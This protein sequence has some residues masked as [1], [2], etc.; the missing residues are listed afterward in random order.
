MRGSIESSPATGDPTYL[1]SIAVPADL[2][3]RRPAQPRQRS[4]M[5]LVVYGFST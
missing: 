2:S 1:N 5:T 3:P 4:R